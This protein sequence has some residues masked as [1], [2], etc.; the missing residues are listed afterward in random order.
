MTRYIRLLVAV[1]ACL[2]FSTGAYAHRNAAVDIDHSFALPG[3]YTLNTYGY[4]LPTDPGYVDYIGSQSTWWNSGP[5]G[6][7]YQEIDFKNQDAPQFTTTVA[8]PSLVSTYTT[9]LTSADIN[10]FKTTPMPYANLFGNYYKGDVLDMTAATDYVF[11]SATA[12]TPFDFQGTPG[13]SGIRFTDVKDSMLVQFFSDDKND[14]YVNIAVNGVPLINLDTWEQGW[15]YFVLSGLG[16]GPNTVTLS[17]LWNSDNNSSI[18]SPH[19]NTVDLNSTSDNWLHRLPGDPGYPN[20]DDFHV[21]FIAYDPVS[22]PEPATLM[23]FGLG[24][25]G[26]ACLRYMKRRRTK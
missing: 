25:A 18:P 1:A 20:P 26:S 4:Y 12:G 3:G 14:G 10:S 15:W 9:D 17:T 23:L 21:F 11:P 16:P 8:S 5:A 6:A 7:G 22:T 2:L 24:L 19:I 13:P